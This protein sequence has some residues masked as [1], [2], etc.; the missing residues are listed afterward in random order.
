MADDRGRLV[1][2]LDH[3]SHMVGNLADRFSREH[4]RVLGRFLHSL[5]IVGPARRERYKSCFLK[6]RGPA[7]PAA[8]EQPQSV[9]EDDRPPAARVSTVHLFLIELFF[10]IQ[11]SVETSRRHV[12]HLLCGGTVQRH[13]CGACLSGSPVRR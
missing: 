7:I 1:K 3:A 6:Q 10:E 13:E 2:F 8:W 12:I 11:W 5:R 4:L 9:N